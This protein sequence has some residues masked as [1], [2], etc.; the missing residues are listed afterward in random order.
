MSKQNF[1]D[2]L[3]NLIKSDLNLK[4]EYKC[5]FCRITK[6]ISLKNLSQEIT[7]NFPHFENCEMV[8]VNK[9]EAKW[10]KYIC[11]SEK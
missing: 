6:V 1:V 9:I 3:E 4:K 8:K 11:G 2:Q 5:P 10:L 7:V